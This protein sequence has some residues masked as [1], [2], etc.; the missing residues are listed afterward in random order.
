ML[1]RAHQ[2]G[3]AAQREQMTLL[4][5]QQQQQQSH[6]ALSASG[7]FVNAGVMLSCVSLDGRCVDANSVTTQPHTAAPHASVTQHG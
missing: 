3:V 2:R 6:R 7:L 1:Q 4:L 5:A